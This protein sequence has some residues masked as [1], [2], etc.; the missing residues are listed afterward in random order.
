MDI[1]ALIQRWLTPTSLA[2]LFG[3]IVWGIQL[4]FVA[5]HNAEELSVLKEAIQTIQDVDQ[6]VLTA[7][8]RNT[9]VQQHLLDRMTDHEAMMDSFQLEH[10]EMIN[11]MAQIVATQKQIQSQLY[12]NRYYD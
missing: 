12:G 11:S 8:A 7:Q 6:R 5:L 10:K 4:N 1:D 9:V 2:I 3:A